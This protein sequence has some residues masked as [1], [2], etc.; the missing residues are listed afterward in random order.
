MIQDQKSKLSSLQKRILSAIVLFVILALVLYMGDRWFS[1]F[2]GLVLGLAL[3]EWSA[4]VK[5]RKPALTTAVRL[6]YNILGGLVLVLAIGSLY[7]LYATLPDWRSGAGFAASGLAVI[8]WVFSL[9]WA[10]DIAAFFVGRRIGGAKLAPK[11]SPNKTWSGAIGGAIAAAL[12][13][14]VYSG[15]AT[16]WSLKFLALAAVFGL[17]VSVFAQLGDLME[18]AAKRYFQ[19]KDSGRIIPGHGGILDRIDGLLFVVPL[20][21]LMGLLLHGSPLLWLGGR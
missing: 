13:S 17:M 12:V 1:I 15:M 14:L 5:N 16:G 2:Q 9:V 19:V 6:G 4:M 11:I 20:I 10:T 8:L 3:A 18:S 7:R 21:A